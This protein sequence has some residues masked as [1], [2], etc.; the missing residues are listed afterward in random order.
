MA[1][2]FIQEKLEFPSVQNALADGLLAI[3]G[4]LTKERMLLAYRSG[5]FPWFSEEDPILWWAPDPRFVLFPEYL[6]ISKSMKQLFNKNAF[7]VSLDRDFSSVLAN[8]ANIK[9]YGQKGTWITPDMID[10]YQTLFD[11]GWAHSVEVWKGDDLVGGLFGVAIGKM[12]FGESMFSKV[13][14]A[15]KYG[16][17]ELVQWLE[18][19]GFDLIDCQ[20]HTAHLGSLGAVH[21][22]RDE[23]MQQIEDSIDKSSINSTWSID[24]LA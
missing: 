23:Y 1:I 5:I 14:N 17:I 2:S 11:E 3:G 19:N 12:F 6:K 15:S 8:C 24:L 16:F 18:K 7:E 13:S 4:D 22:S 10:A 20:L 9:R 21:I